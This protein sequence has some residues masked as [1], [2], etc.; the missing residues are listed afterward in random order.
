MKIERGGSCNSSD[1]IYAAECRKHKKLYIGQ[2]KNQVDRRFFGHRSNI[3]KLISS[4]S[5]G[6]VRGTELSEHFSSSPHSP[7][8]LRLRIL[9]NNQ[10]WRDIDRLTMEDYYICKLKTIEPDGLNVRHGILPNF[11]IINLISIT[12][13]LFGFPHFILFLLFLYLF[14]IPVNFTLLRD[15][16]VLG[17][18]I[19]RMRNFRTHN[20]SARSIRSKHSIFRV[21][22]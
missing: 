10:K 19:F 22:R 13:V 6:D 18:I 16:L 17:I 14:I 4:T 7:K 12:I 8:E 2:S 11:I 1:T 5:N 20:S 21:C 3:K 15:Y 9:D